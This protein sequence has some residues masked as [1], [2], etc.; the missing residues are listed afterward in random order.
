M[1][2]L[3]V[4]FWRDIPA[5]VL[6]RE[7]RRTT[8][9]V[10]LPERFEKAIDMAA[11]RAGATDDD[12]YVSEWRKTPL[13]E[14]ES[15]GRAEAEALAARLDREFPPERLRTFVHAFGREA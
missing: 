3:V 14:V 7:G 15:D 9:R 8:V 2:Q 1:A 10:K 12:A 5:Q 11:M 4:V 6:V 13:G